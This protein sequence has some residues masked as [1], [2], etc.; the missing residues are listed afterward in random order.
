MGHLSF[1]DWP[2]SCGLFLTSEIQE[3]FEKSELMMCHGLAL[4]GPLNAIGHHS[5]ND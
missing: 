2:M 4:F 1:N 3:T 5:F